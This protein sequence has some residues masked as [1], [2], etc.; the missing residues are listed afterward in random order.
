[1]GKKFLIDTNILLEYLGNQ[2]ATDAQNYVNKII[3]NDFNISVINRIEIL[4]HPSATNQLLD[5]LNLAN[6]YELTQEI[7]NQTI[8]LRK[9]NKIKLPDA[10]IAATAL[11]Y[12][13][14]IISRNAKDFD[15][16]NGLKVID[17]HKQ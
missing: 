3:A 12:Q 7:V 6:Q 16:I 15:R 1:M 9:V 14:T 10:V 13:L 4:G 11:V 5:F 8:E 17:P 2:L